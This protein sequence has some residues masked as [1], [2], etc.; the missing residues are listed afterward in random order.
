[1]NAE[2]SRREFLKTAGLGLG[3]LSLSG[4]ALREFG[5]SLLQPDQRPNIVLIMADDLGKEW[6]SC[7]GAEGIET[8]NI[9]RLARDGI[10]FDNAYSMP[11]CTPSRVSLLTGQYPFTHGWV[12]HWGVPQFGQGCRFDEKFYT[13]FPRLLQDAGY[14]T[15]IAGKWQLNDFRI[16][17]EVLAAHGFDDWCVW[18]GRE[19]GNPASEQRYWD[20]YIHTRSGSNIHYLAYGPDVYCNFLIDFARQNKDRPFF[21]YYPMCMIHKPFAQTPAEPLVFGPLDKFRAMIRY[22]DTLIGRLMDSLGS[23][24]VRD[25]TVVIFLTDNGTARDV[26]GVLNGRTVNGGKSTLREAG[27]NSP[28]IISA[29][30]GPTGIVSDALVDITDIYPTLIDFAG[31]TIPR[32][33]S[34]DGKSFAGLVDGFSNGDREWILSMGFG[35]AKLNEA[36]RVVNVSDFADRVIR[37]KQYKLVITEG[38]ASA[39]YDLKNDPG[40]ETNILETANTSQNAVKQHLLSVIRSLPSKDADRQYL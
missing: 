7:Y 40:E 31:T 33:V 3:L 22:T 2:M 36:K 13:A 16:E 29:P 5:P 8:P 24:G 15:A 20:P 25:N 27:V 10:R 34:V 30:S 6:I 18:T 38:D 17:S 39:F 21:L 28:F 4:C 37:D 11:Q 9:D 14:T 1:M 35:L 12:N 26:S 19:S 23:L 32:S